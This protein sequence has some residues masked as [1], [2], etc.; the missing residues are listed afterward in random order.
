MI[1]KKLLSEVLSLKYPIRIIHHFCKGQNALNYDLHVE[2]ALF[3]ESINIYELAHRCKEWAYSKGYDI[4]SDCNGADVCNI[5]SNYSIA[6]FHHNV[7]EPEAI[8][9]A[10][11]YIMEQKNDKTTIHARLL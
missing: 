2:C 11:E 7:T 6:P 4:Y 5:G 3:Q 10:C 1:S 8:F 9:K